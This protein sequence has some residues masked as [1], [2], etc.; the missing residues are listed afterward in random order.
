MDFLAFPNMASFGSL[1]LSC[2]SKNTSHLLIVAQRG[3]PPLFCVMER[4]WFVETD[5]GLNPSSVIFL[6][7]LVRELK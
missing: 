7:H 4:A 3:N 6:V 2:F 1:N 5:L